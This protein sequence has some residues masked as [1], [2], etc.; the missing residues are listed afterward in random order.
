MENF[1]LKT[2][3]VVLIVQMNLH[4]EVAQAKSESSHELQRLELIRGDSSGWGI[5]WEKSH[6]TERIGE[7][8]PDC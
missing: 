7:Q 5:N 4:Y 3:W 6:G 1:S 8:Q 2:F